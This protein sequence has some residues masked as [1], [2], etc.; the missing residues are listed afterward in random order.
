MVNR[1]LP[2]RKIKEI[3]RLKYDCG[4]SEREITRS[5]RVSRSTIADYLMRFQAAGLRWP[6]ATTLGEVQLE[7][8]LFPTQHLSNL[9]QRPLPDCQYIYDQLRTYR[10]FNLTLSQLWI[11]YKEEHPDGYQYTQFCDYYRQWRGKLDYCMR[12]EHRGGEKVFIDYCDGLTIVDALNGEILT[13][14]LFVAVWGASNYT[15]A[16]ATYSQTLPEWISLSCA[17]PGVFSM[18]SPG[19]GI[20]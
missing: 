8:R 18:C 16:E 3:L 15:Y 9:I 11:E 14:Q 10:K 20:R 2:M 12:Q 17:C 1:R 13:T 5:C 19:P 6:E 4:L 7:E